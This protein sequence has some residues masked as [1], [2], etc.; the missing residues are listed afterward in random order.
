M[1]TKQAKRDPRDTSWMADPGPNP[2]GESLRP[3]KISHSL[4][5]PYHFAFIYTTHDNAR[6]TD[7]SDRADGGLIG[8]HIEP[9]DIL[10]FDGSREAGEGEIAMVEVAPGRWV[11]RILRQGERGREY[12]P[13]AGGD[14]AYPPL[15]GVY[16]TYGVLAAILRDFDLGDD[17]DESEEAGE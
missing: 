8:R 17:E 4:I 6:I 15:R 5:K 1:R 13:D 3:W 16:R 9:G 11:A 7:M 2:P 14:P 12:H 10:L